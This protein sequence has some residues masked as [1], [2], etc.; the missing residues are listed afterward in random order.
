MSALRP[1]SVRRMTTLRSSVQLRARR[2]LP[3][4][5]IRLRTGQQMNG[6]AL[7]E[8]IKFV[9]DKIAAKAEI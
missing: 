8:A 3:S 7:D 4:A 6:L 1:A 5:S 9:L 2:T